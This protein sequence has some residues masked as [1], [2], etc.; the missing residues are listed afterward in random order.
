VQDHDVYRIKWEALANKDVRRNFANSVTSLFQELREC[1]AD[2]S[3]RNGFIC[4]SDVL[5]E[6]TQSWEIW[7]KIAA[8]WN[9]GTKNAIQEKEVACKTWL[10]NKSRICLHP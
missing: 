5:T 7:Q 2:G 9:K 10:P 1:T 8:W 6:A 3:S 4:F